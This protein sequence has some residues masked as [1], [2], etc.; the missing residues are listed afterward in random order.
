M[1]DV[2]VLGRQADVT[3]SVDISSEPGGEAF[4]VYPPNGPRLATEV[5]T[6]E[7][8]APAHGDDHVVEGAK[9]TAMYDLKVLAGP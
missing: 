6:I 5:T 4:D 9:G 2:Y 8:M 1:Y 3:L 7:L